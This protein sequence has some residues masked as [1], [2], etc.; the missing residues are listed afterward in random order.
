MDASM[1]G[2]A[3]AAYRRSLLANTCGN[4]LEIGFGTG[5]NLPFYPETVTKLTAVDN[6]SGARAIA[7]RRIQRTP[8]RFEIESQ[9]LSGESLPMADETFD[10]AVST[11][12]L[13]SIKNASQALQEI[14]RVLKPGGRF[15]FV[16][17]G[18]SDNPKVQVWQ[19]R[20]NPIQRVVGDGCN[21]NRDIR[22]LVERQFSQV[23]IETFPE[24]SLPAVAGYFYKG[25]AVK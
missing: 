13:C 12:T 3:L 9:T 15:F 4:V 14:R 25:I 5:L 20:L 18:L 17:H 11:W 2:E 1:S 21:F 16:E 10:C 6:N 23:D 22:Q 7:A 8:H 19:N 24:P